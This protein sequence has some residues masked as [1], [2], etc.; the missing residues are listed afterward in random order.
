MRLDMVRMRPR[1][2]VPAG[3]EDSEL[4]P[5]VARVPFLVILRLHHCE[6]PNQRGHFLLQF[7]ANFP[8]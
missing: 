3:T 2:L 6:H 1:R 4:L 8:A 7:H 5:Q